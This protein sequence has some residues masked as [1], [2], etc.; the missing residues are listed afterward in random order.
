MTLTTS[1]WIE[2]Q[3]TWTAGPTPMRYGAFSRAHG[4]LGRLQMDRNASL[5]PCPARGRTARASSACVSPPP[6]KPCLRNRIEYP[7]LSFDGIPRFHVAVKR[8]V[9]AVMDLL[10]EFGVTV[11]DLRRVVF[12]EAKGRLLAAVLDRLGIAPLLDVFGSGTVRQCSSA[13]L[14]IAL[15]HAVRKGR[16]R[17]AI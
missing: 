11:E 12:H 3:P 16:W 5:R 15:D 8:L 9:T 10:K 17:P 7:I 14:P 2:H 1:A 4:V 6:I 13:S